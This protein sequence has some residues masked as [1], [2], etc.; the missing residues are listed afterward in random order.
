L[1]R[2][3]VRV[4][5]GNLIQLEGWKSAKWKSNAS[6]DNLSLGRRMAMAS[7]S[8]IAQKR[9]EVENNMME[10]DASDAVYKF[11]HAENQRQL[12]AKKWATE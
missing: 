5:A 1:K 9:W 6:R 8:K 10:V 12:N 4:A 11:D 3:I 2:I 7:D